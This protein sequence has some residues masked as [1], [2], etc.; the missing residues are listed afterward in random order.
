MYILLCYSYSWYY[1][2]DKTEKAIEKC[3][4]NNRDLIFDYDPKGRH[5]SNE[6]D[7]KV[8][9]NRARDIK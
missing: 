2:N 4:E 5:K 9:L 7:L 6:I 1:F 8:L 3:I